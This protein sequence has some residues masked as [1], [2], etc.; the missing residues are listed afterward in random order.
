MASSPQAV[1]LVRVIDGDTVIIKH[2][3]LLSTFKSQKRIRLYGI[4][5]PESDQKGGSHATQH[6]K[7]LVGSGSNI[8]M[9]DM[10]RDRYGRTVAIIY[11]RRKSA[12]QSFNRD[13][14]AAGHARWYRQYGAGPYGFKEAEA[15]ARSRK[16]G[17]WSYQAED[18]WDYRARQRRRQ[19]TAARVRWILLGILAIAITVVAAAVCIP[20]ILA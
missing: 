5:A 16:L 17:I 3:G 4:D 10:G 19:S 18:P 20:E 13:M 9:I 15:H 12:E 1:N 11:H 6:L 7:K 14:V 2:R 8:R